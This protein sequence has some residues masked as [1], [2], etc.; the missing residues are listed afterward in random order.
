MAQAQAQV[1]SREAS[2]NSAEHHG[3]FKCDGSS[4]EPARSR[5]HPDLHRFR[6]GKTPNELFFMGHTRSE[7]RHGLIASA[8]TQ[9]GGYVERAVAK[10]LLKGVS[11]CAEKQITRWAGKG[12]NVVEFAQPC[13]AMNVVTVREAEQGGAPI[14]RGRCD[15]AERLRHVPAEEKAQHRDAA[16]RRPLVNS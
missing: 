16:G 4:N 11:Q 2:A 15:C 8:A 6:E 9:A 1:R 3:G 10:T 14:G 13:H 12:Y 5:S 7:N